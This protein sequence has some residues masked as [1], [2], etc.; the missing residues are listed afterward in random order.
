[1]RKSVEIKV[2]E[3][4]GFYKWLNEFA[5]ALRLELNWETLKKLEFRADC[6]KLLTKNNISWSFQSHHER[7]QV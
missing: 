4:V 7:E 1:M 2:L 6:F 5:V 3:S